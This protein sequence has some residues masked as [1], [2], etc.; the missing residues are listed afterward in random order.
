MNFYFVNCLSRLLKITAKPDISAS[1]QYISNCPHPPL[2]G[3]L[4]QVAPVHAAEP[5]ALLQRVGE[6]PPERLRQEE[7]RDAA[8]AGEGAH[9]HQRQDPVDGSLQR[10][11]M[12][13]QNIHNIYIVQY[14]FSKNCENFSE[15]S[16]T[17]PEMVKLS[18]GEDIIYTVL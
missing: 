15:I 17:P 3:T 6:V 11:E 5:L 12:F 16:L 1:C 4:Q 14:A 18:R 2:L 10:G 7:R 13:I 9:D 8:Q